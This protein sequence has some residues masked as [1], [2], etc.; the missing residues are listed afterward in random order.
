MSKSKFKYRFMTDGELLAAALAVSE[1]NAAGSDY[2]SS[3]DLTRDYLKLRLSHEES[4]KF[5]VIWLDSRHSVLDFQVLFHGTVDG[6]SVYPREVVKAGLAVNAAACV[7]SHNHPSGDPSPSD[8]DKRITQRLQEA[9]RLIDIRVL[10]HLVVGKG[11]LFSFAE[12]GY[13]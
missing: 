12:A 8:A 9:L 10:D 7:L 5:C 4:E 2:L 1:Q 11:K 13:M 3:P 6:A